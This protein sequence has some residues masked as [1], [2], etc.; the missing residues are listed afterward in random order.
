LPGG[1]ARRWVIDTELLREELDQAKFTGHGDTHV[2]II[3]AG[4]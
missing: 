4:A 1:A 3:E 2:S